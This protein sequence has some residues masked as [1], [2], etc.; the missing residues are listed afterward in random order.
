MERSEGMKTVLHIL[1]TNSYSGAEN[2]AIT[3]IRAMHKRY[4]DYRLIYVSPDGPIRER[5]DSECVEFEPIEK[6]SRRNIRRLIKKYHPSVIHAHDFTASIVSAFSTFKVPVISHIHNNSPW[7]SKL[8]V[9]SVAY[10]LSCFRYRKMLGVSPSVFDEF[11]FGKLFKKKS[12]II[13]NPIDLEKIRAAAECAELKD[14]FDVVFLGRLSDAKQPVSFVEIIGEVSAEMDISAVIIGDGELKGEV[15][16]KIDTLGLSQRVRLLGFV[17]N[18]HGILAASRLLVLTSSWEGY[19]LVAAEALALGK[20][21]VATPVGGI[22][23]IITG[24]EG[25]LCDTPEKI[26]SAIKELLSK[27]EAY[28]EASRLAKIRADEIDNLDS[29]TEKI[30]RYYSGV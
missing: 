14:S 6:I 24:G 10:G 23:T 15:E 18:P 19:G 22:P 12:E 29:Y 17:D 9:R 1:N 25:R 30:N 28:A 7:L 8:G 11:I 16:R 5:L 21:V 27:P 2:V 4:P 3:L 13:G 20:P 26:V